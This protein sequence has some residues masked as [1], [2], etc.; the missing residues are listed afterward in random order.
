M[1]LNDTSA[2]SYCIQD[3]LND[4]IKSRGWDQK[5]SIRS[6]LSCQAND[7]PG[8]RPKRVFS[9]KEE[10][11]K[12][13]DF[14][15]SR[16]ERCRYVAFYGNE[17]IYG[18]WTEERQGKA[19]LKVVTIDC[20]QRASLTLYAIPLHTMKRTSSLHL[21]QLLLSKVP[22]RRPPQEQGGNDSQNAFTTCSCLHQKQR[23]SINSHP[24]NLRDLPC[25]VA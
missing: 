11:C 21:R 14:G 25:E 1:I 5:H 7:R 13:D 15:A 22:G 3:I 20:H 17:E 24:L 4:H 8:I 18:A 6:R 16:S 10:K 9:F 2:Y 19:N 23:C 12:W